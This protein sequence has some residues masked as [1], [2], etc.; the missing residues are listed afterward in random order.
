[1]LLNPCTDNK[2]MAKIFLA[3]YF[4]SFFHQVFLVLIITAVVSTINVNGS[5]SILVKLVSKVLNKFT[6]LLVN[7]IYLNFRFDSFGFW[8]LNALI[9]HIV[10]H[11]Y[12]CRDFQR[13]LQNI[14]K[15]SAKK[16]NTQ[17]NIREKVTEKRLCKLIVLG[18]K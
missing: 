9:K 14:E 11:F 13:C 5:L 4:W 1:M 2:H 15:H 3:R 8:S 10:F 16:K 17:G 7:I 12:L 18:I 6:M